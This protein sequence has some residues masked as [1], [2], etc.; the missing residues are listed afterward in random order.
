VHDHDVALARLRVGGVQMMLASRVT[1][2]PRTAIDNGIE[3]CRSAS[4][5]DATAVAVPE[6]RHLRERNGH[7]ERREVVNHIERARALF[8]ATKDIVHKAV[9]ADMIRY[10]EGRLKDL[11]VSGVR[12]DARGLANAS[13]LRL[14]ALD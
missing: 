12:A 8:R 11:C 9:L 4:G 10:L 14:T 5:H 3:R 7:D 13:Y 1:V 2:T 6:D